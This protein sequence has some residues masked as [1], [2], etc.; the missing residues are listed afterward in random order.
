MDTLWKFVRDYVTDLL[1]D[2]SSVQTTLDDIP[3]GVEL[4]AIAEAGHAFDW[5]ADEPDLYS[6]DDGEPV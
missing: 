1:A 4:A 5:L 6:L 3:A 2:K